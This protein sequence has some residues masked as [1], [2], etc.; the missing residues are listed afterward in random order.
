[1]PKS[2]HEQNGRQKAIGLLDQMFNETAE[3]KGN[4]E[5]LRLALQVEFLENPVKFF[6]TFIIPLAPKD[7]PTL[8]EEI[9]AHV[10]PDGIC[11]QMDALTSSSPGSEKDGNEEN[12]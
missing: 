12:T 1:M 10:T 11:L 3:G 4:R 9:W 7:Q 5:V 2:M 8:A 6:K